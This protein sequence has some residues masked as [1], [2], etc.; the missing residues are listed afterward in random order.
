MPIVINKPAP[1]PHPELCVYSEVEVGDCGFCCVRYM[2]WVENYFDY[3]H[4]L[5]G[6]KVDEGND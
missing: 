2:E 4:D 6:D 1:P 3:I 5:R